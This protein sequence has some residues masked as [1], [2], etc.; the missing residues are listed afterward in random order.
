MQYV[1]ELNFEC[2]LLVVDYRAVY[3]TILLFLSCP[4]ETDQK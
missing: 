4:T 3:N 1:L 2:V